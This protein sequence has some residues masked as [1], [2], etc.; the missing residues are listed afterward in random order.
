MKGKSITMTIGGIIIGIFAYSLL[1]QGDIFY[2]VA[3]IPCAL[4]LLYFGLI[5]NKYKNKGYQNVEHSVNS[6]FNLS[7][8][9]D[10]NNKND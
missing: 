5:R 4:A 6:S 1:K 2:G 8:S 3:A 7:G 10:P 9:K